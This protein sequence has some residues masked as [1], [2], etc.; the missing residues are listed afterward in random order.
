MDGSMLFAQLMAPY[1]ERGHFSAKLFGILSRF[2]I[3]YE[4]ALVKKGLNPRDFQPMISD[5]IERVEEQ[6]RSLYPFPHFHRRLKKPFDYQK[7]GLDFIRP[8]IDWQ[9]STVTGFAALKAMRQQINLKHNVILLA[10]HQIEADPQVIN[11]LLEPIDA[12]LGDQMIFVAGERVVVDPCAVPFSLGCNLL[13]IYSKKYIDHPPDHRLRKQ[14]HNKKTMESMSQLLAEGGACIYVALSGGRDRRGRDHRVEV[15]PFDPNNLEMFQLMA[16]KGKTPT[17]FYPLSL[18]TYTILP[19]PESIQI[20]LGEERIAQSG[21]CHLHFGDEV[22][23][24]QLSI[25]QGLD[26]QESRRWK[27]DYVYNI[28]KHNYLHFNVDY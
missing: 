20:E 19:P 13:C 22:H 24:D 14:L 6:V 27:S 12:A 16:K 1:L 5:L 15:A 8:L 28:V 2:L 26:K 3:S 21:A 18:A 4:Q 25:P 23:F 7:L 9:Q 10:N 11:L 17:H